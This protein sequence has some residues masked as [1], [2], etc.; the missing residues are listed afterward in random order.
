LNGNGAIRY[1]IYDFLIDFNRNYASIFY[2]LG[3]IESYLSKVANVNLPHA[4]AFG[5]SVGGDSVWVL[6]MSS[7]SEN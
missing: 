1:S 4:P 5:A 6:P 2:R 3:V 7:A